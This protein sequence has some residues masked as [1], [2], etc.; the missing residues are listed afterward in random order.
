MLDGD[1]RLAAKLARA[2]GL[3]H[4]MDWV[5]VFESHN[6]YEWAMQI[7]LNTVEPWGEDRADFRA[8]MNTAQLVASQSVSPK[9]EQTQN[10]IN[11]MRTYLPLYHTE[12]E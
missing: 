7:A 12:D 2:A 6:E 4:P 9:Q 1:I 5:R 11:A 10:I 8:A 3:I